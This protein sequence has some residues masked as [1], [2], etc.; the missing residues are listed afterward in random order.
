MSD[1]AVR[2]AGA[3]GPIAISLMGPPDWPILIGMA[4]C[5]LVR[6]PMMRLKTLLPDF[7]MLALATLGTAVTIHDNNIAGGNAFWCGVGFGGAG[8]ALIEIGKS[9]IIEGFK[10]RF[11]D[12]ARVLF[13][14]KK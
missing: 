11:Q 12:A 14:I 9:A 6:L 8:S 1:A 10:A 13:G 3:V 5:V 7:C 4:S 2:T